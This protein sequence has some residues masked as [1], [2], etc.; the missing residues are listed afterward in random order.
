MNTHNTFP[1]RLQK[2]WLYVFLFNVQK[3]YESSH[4]THVRKGRLVQCSHNI[5]IS[6]CHGP[7]RS[8]TLARNFPIPHLL[9]TYPPKQ[10]L[11]PSQRSRPLSTGPAER[12][13]CAGLRDRPF[14]TACPLAEQSETLLHELTKAQQYN[15][16]TRW[17]VVYA[18]SYAFGLKSDKD[19]Q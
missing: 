19:T 2:L 6:H 8:W 3:M 12:V 14:H 5:S 9:H 10:L 11:V 15:Q 17:V 13:K 7:I 18:I 4:E 16:E 1:P